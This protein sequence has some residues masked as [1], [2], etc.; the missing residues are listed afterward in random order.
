MVTLSDVD[1]AIEQARVLGSSLENEIIHIIPASY[2][3]DSSSNL[4]NPL[5]LYSHKLEVDLYLICAKQAC[6]QNLS[7]VIAQAGCDIKELYFSGL[8]TSRA[9]FTNDALSGVNVL[10]DIGSDTTEILLF[11]NASLVDLEILSAG[12]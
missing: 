10:C 3:I 11:K 9:V 4:I 5:G 2:S 8:A 12:G 6:V 1:R 7:R